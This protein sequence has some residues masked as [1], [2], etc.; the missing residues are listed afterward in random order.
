MMGNSTTYPDGSI[1]LSD[2][3]TVQQIGAILQPLTLGMWGQSVVSTSG[4][5]RLGWAI[6]GQPFVDFAS[7]DVCFLTA[8]LKDDPYDKIRDRTYA[9]NTD[10]NVTET[11]NYT[12][13]WEI[14]WCFYGPN[15]VD[16]TRLIRSGLFQD[17]FTDQLAL[18]QLFPMSE[19]PESVRVPEQLNGQWFDRSDLK[20]E[21]YEFV[22]ESIQRQT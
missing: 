13:V 22:T 18:M 8:T 10:P 12:R 4:L 17:Y 20:C 16:N 11:W 21:M 19:F 1:L 3:L 9:A 2:A 14:K 15:A 5:V 7:T 6:E